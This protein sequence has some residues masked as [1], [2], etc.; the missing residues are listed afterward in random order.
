MRLC[1][2]E[3]YSPQIAVALRDLGH[4]VVAAAERSDLVSLSDAELLAA[5]VREQRALLTEN[6]RDFAPLVHQMAA[7][8]ERHFGLVH[9]SPRSMPRNRDTIGAFVESLR[10]LLDRFPADDALVDRIKWLESPS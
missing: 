9:S 2:D 8:G 4:D 10:A 6:V 7:A 3:H 5:L 1:L